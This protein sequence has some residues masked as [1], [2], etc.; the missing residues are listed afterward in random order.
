MPAS[1]GLTFHHDK[2]G[3]ESVHDDWTLFRKFDE[4]R[5]A[6]GLC[7]WLRNEQVDARA[8]GGV[9]YVQRGQ[10]HR[11]RWIVEH[12]PPTHDELLALAAEGA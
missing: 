8:D 3:E 5:A 9:V 6:T 4:P 10:H 12:L 1:R 7:R 11:A 2:A